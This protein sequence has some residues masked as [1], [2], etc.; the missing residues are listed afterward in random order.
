MSGVCCCGC[1]YL[2]ECVL[3]N[4]IKVSALRAKTT[5][6]EVFRTCMYKSKLNFKLDFSRWFLLDFSICLFFHIHMK[7]NYFFKYEFRN[8]VFLL[9][10]IIHYPKLSFIIWKTSGFVSNFIMEGCEGIFYFLLDWISSKFTRQILQRKL[11]K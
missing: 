11:Q 2:C 9:K 6:S 3:P 8:I 10:I 5:F 4:Q 7:H 1:V